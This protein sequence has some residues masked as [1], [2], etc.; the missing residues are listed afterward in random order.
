MF[1]TWLM[2]CLL[3]ALLASTSRA[4]QSDW[5]T[6]AGDPLDAGS[7]TVQVDPVAREREPRKMRVRVNRA[8]PRTSWDGVPYRSYEANVLFDCQRRSARYLSIRYHLQAN[9]AGAPERIVDYGTG[10]ERPMVFKDM[11]PNPTA[12]IVAA[13]CATL[14]QP[15]AGR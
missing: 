8:M 10:P 9:W 15:A 2:P 13:A 1:L 6:V 3:T 5:F 4:A 11:Q 12:R 7:N 14:P